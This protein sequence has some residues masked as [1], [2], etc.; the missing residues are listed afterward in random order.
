MLKQSH[1]YYDQVQGQ[2]AITGK[3]R[4]DFFVNT[5]HGYVMQ[6][7]YPDEKYWASLASNPEFIYLNYVAPEL[8]THELKEKYEVDFAVNEIMEE[9]LSSISF[10][11]KRPLRNDSESPPC[12]NNTKDIPNSRRK[13]K[14]EGSVLVHPS[15]RKSIPIYISVENAPLFANIWVLKCSRV[16]VQAGNII[17]GIISYA[18]IKMILRKP[19]GCAK[20]AVTIYESHKIVAT[21]SALTINVKFNPVKTIHS[22][23]YSK[24]L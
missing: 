24:S 14:G 6:H 1:K 15:K 20:N 12:M 13:R 9:M 22:F 4:C 3:A 16:A 18:L 7:F 21:L 10:I 8:V 23:F 2:L 5:R 19:A 11:D 17:S